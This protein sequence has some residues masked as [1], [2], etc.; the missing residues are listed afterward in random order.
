MQCSNNL[1]QL[2]LACHNRH[3]V[4]E[5]FPAA[6]LQPEFAV[7]N[8]RSKNWTADC[9]QGNLTNLTHQAGYTLPLLPFIEQTAPYSEISDII[10]RGYANSTPAPALTNTPTG[11]DNIGS[12]VVTG[13]WLPWNNGVNNFF[14]RVRISGFVCPSDGERDGILN[15]SARIN[16]RCS[17]GDHW[18]G[19]DQD[20]TNRG[21][22]GKGSQ[23]VCSMGGIPDGTSNTIL[24]S[25]GVIAPNGSTR[26][27]KGGIAMA[28]SPRT[29]AAC[30]AK[31]GA[32][33]T[34]TDPWAGTTIFGFR[35]G[36]GRPNFTT[37][38]TVMPPNTLS[39][40]W[41]ALTAGNSEANTLANA[42]SYH[43]G[44]V[45]AALADGS[46][47]FIS[48]TINVENTDTVAGPNPSGPS[49]YGVWGALGTRDGGESRGL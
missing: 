14:T 49:A 34:L 37:F 21:I 23:F 11:E 40:S 38:F 6:L 26:R 47:R 42:A 2:A 45:N 33:S 8:N 41:D 16:Y 39:C 20:S 27:A 25:E 12:Q 46:V 3:D 15:Q 1:K 7:E 18:I 28:V 32:D 9:R 30:R 10:T 29:P 36:H 19:W 24:L 43:T 22:F 48:D 4:T 17:R 31:L 13:D 5:T 35:W 44:G